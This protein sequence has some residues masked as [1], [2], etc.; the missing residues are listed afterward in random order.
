MDQPVGAADAGGDDLTEMSGP[1][2]MSGL[3]EVSGWPQVVHQ[4]AGMVSVQLDIPVQDAY[5]RLAEHAQRC[6]QP[7]EQVAAQVAERRLQWN[8]GQA[9]GPPAA[10]AE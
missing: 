6:G 4:A 2:Q 7:V 1:A 5:Q 3:A 10:T 8:S 9:P